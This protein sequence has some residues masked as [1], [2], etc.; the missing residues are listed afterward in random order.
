M[1]D[2]LTKTTRRKF[3]NKWLY[4]VTLKI[5]GAVLLRIYN[6]QQVDEFC[7]LAACPASKSFTNWKQRAWRNR[8]DIRDLLRILDDSGK[9]WA[10]RI[11]GEN[12][13]IYVN[14]KDLYEELSDK[15]EI[16]LIHRFEPDLNNLDI[17]DERNGK[18]MTVK[19]LPHGRY[20]YRVYLL[21]HN[22]ND[23]HKFIDW[24]ESLKPR[25]TCTD[26]IKKWFMS[27]TG[28]WDRRYILVE[29]EGTIM[30]MKLRNSDVIGTVYKFEVIE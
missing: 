11:E 16:I 1:L 26:A 21:P 27:T 29:D 30:M 2:Q 3:Y 9:D 17:L 28:N 14:D 25:V 22:C 19:R 10:K 20:G 5:S 24:L 13:D 12:V 23:K 15:F 7:S 6:R 4:K 8:H 18:T